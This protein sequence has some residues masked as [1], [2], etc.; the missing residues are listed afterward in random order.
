MIGSLARGRRLVAG[1]F[2]C[3]GH[4][5]ELGEDSSLWTL[6]LPAPE[7]QAELHGFGWLDDL[8]AVGDRAARDRAR[9]WTTDWIARYG[10]GRG[11]GWTPEL[12]GRRLIRWISH[13]A[14]LMDGLDS[15]LS[16]AGFRALGRQVAF[17]SRRW[18]AA[19][20]GL[21]RFEALVGLTCAAL[22]LK[23]MERFIGPAIDGL[24]RECAN[25]IDRQG[26]IPT[27]NP[28]DLLE[29]FTLLTWAAAVLIETNRTLPEAHMIAMRHIAPLLR[30]VRHADGNLA[31]FHG[32]GCGREGWLDHALATSGVRKG[33]GEGL[34]M[35]Y[36]RLA[37][38][39]TSI[40]VDASA[41]PGGPASGNAHA[42]TL[43]F[44]LTSGRRALIVNCGSGAAFGADWR[45]AA[46]ATPSHSTLGIDGMSSSRFGSGA[47]RAGRG[48]GGELLSD[49]PSVV[50]F[51]SQR[52]VE[53][54]IYRGAHDGYRK[55]HGLTHERTLCLSTD[56]RVLEGEDA[57]TIQNERDMW[58]FDRANDRARLQG[59]AC[60]IRFHLHPDVNAVLDA[61][62]STVS[63]ALKSGEVWVFRHDGAAELSL[64]PSVYLEADRPGPLKTM[65]IILSARVED[66]SNR[67]TWSLAKTEGTPVAL[68]DLK[69]AG[70]VSAPADE[71]MPTA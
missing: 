43:A 22:A 38:G 52:Y 58:R 4:P 28:E 44:E 17:L 16:T 62:G 30:A 34:S 33:P 54:I 23:G 55:T 40:V 48:G 27:R 20:G 37:G 49:Q 1:T 60:A 21:P 11:P 7:S 68:R 65:Q 13:G 31:R 46:R 18:K 64:E 3:A 50:T 67:L 66:Y 71:G 56:G 69:S 47:A 51:S 10:A 19:P 35:G 25:G 8:A 61:D 36:F 41:P 26:G 39:R 32:G 57:L 14:F 9:A 2:P 42:S 45:R 29:V 70:R 53:G 24:S 6:P 15:D 12:T 63:M 5:V 59:I